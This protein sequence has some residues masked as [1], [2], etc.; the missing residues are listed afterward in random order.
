[1]SSSF[2]SIFKVTTFGESHSRGVGAVVDHCP[3]GLVVSEAD[4]Q[5]QLDRRKPGQSRMTT[6][7]DEKDKVTVLSGIENNRTLGTP[8]A[9]MIANTDH[10]PSDYTHLRRV[11]RPSHADYTYQVK[12]GM[13]SASGG[14]RASARET[15]GRVAAGAVADIFLKEVYGI[16]I[17]AWVSAVG[18][19]SAP[20]VDMETIT[21]TEVDRSLV[22]CPDEEAS[23]KMVEAV[24]AVK[25][26]GDS[27]GGIIT[28]ICR[29]VPAGWGE[30]V[31]DKMEAKLAH[32]IMS[33]PAVKGF[34]VGSGFAGS[35]MTGSA[36]N[37]RFVKKG[38]RLGTATNFSGGIQGGITNGEMVT[39][40]VAFKPTATIGLTQISADFDG[41][42]VEIEGKGRH[43]PCVLPRAVPI[44][45]SMAA[46]VLADMALIQQTRMQK[47]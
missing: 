35:R 13:R 5:R 10:R 37:D 3:P 43:D 18:S 12:Y 32:G 21:R 16:D 11:P 23:Q 20:P 46:L 8:I 1:M 6:Q 44:V 24:D 31:F 47:T 39:F 19:L 42:S 25:A 36:H 30:P 29:G 41:N 34:E 14:G 27:I 9:L 45:E 15:A 26:A 40:N 28:C 7:R 2:G 33:I 17:I 22:R 4:I 38:N